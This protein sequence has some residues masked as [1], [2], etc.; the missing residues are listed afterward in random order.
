MH[1]VST[2]GWGRRDRDY[3][4]RIMT[5]NFPNLIKPLMYLS[6]LSELQTRQTQRSTTIPI[7]VKL[8]KP[9]TKKE[10]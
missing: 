1:I 2:R 10:S 5:P 8:S 4:E 3:F 7:I 9:M 6:K